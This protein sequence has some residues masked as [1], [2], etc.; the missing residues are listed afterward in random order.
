M[1]LFLDKMATPVG[2]ITFSF[3]EKGVLHSL[4]F[5]KEG[6]SPVFSLERF[7][8]AANLKNRK[9][10]DDLRRSLEA[11]FS[12]DLLSLEKISIA[13]PGTKFQRSVWEALCEIPAGTTCSYG[14]IASK[15]K[16]PGAM[17]A[18]G[19]ANNANPI[20]IVVPCHRVIGAS[21]AMVGYGSGIARKTWLLRH[22]G[23]DIV[24]ANKASKAMD[25]RQGQLDL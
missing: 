25:P 21:G 20:A 17:R 8:K 7:Y 4:D 14:D 9:S 24:G 2:E 10:P 22:E 5:L 6:R 1:N 3:D 13:L 19:M 11:Y 12:G 23:V 16:N 15:L 18:V